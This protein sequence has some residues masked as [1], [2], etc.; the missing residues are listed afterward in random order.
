MPPFLY[1]CTSVL[2][3]GKRLLPR[4]LNTGGGQL[5]NQAAE[6]QPDRKEADDESRT[7]D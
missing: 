4:A 2:A 7:T 6:K 5:Y 3:D 1:V